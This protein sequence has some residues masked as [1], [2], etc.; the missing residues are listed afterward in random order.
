MAISPQVMSAPNSLQILL[1]GKFPV[2]KIK[3]GGRKGGTEGGGR[4]RMEE[5]KRELR[6]EEGVRGGWKREGERDLLL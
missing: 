2:Y 1:N 6:G 3:E 5:S 4:R